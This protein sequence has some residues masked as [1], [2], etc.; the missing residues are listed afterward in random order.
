MS[1]TLREQRLGALEATALLR[2]VMEEIDVAVFAFDAEQRLRLVNRAGEQL[3]GSSRR[4]CSELTADELGLDEF[5]EGEP[6]RRA[7]EVRGR[8]RAA[9]A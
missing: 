3:L 2:K 1:A 9:G 6:R 5:L 4:S 8:H 7:A